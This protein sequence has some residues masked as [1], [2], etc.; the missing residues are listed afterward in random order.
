MFDMSLAGDGDRYTGCTDL[1]DVARRGHFT[2]PGLPWESVAFDP[3]HACPQ[4]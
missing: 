2:N 3:V 1:V 4:Q